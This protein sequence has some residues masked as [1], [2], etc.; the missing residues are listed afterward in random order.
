MRRSA[1][2]T[3]QRE[4]FNSGEAWSGGGLV[5]GYAE[6]PR[7]GGKAAILHIA[8]NLFKVIDLLK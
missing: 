3:E 2:K 7:K 5:Q 6:T 8:L 1:Q 4:S